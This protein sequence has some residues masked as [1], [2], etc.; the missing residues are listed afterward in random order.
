[1]PQMNWDTARLF[2]GSRF[3]VAGKEGEMH[4]I[5]YPGEPFL[6]QPTEVFAYLGLPQVQDAR[7]PGMVLVHG[8]GGTAFRQ[9]VE[10]WNARGYAAIAMDLSGRGPDGERLPNGGPDQDHPAIFSTDLDWKDLW[11]YHAVAALI[12]ANN[13]LRGLEQ[14]DPG[15]IG[16]TGISWGGY[17]TCIAAGLDPRFGCAIPVYGCGFLQQGSAD[18][19][20]DIFAAMNPE[21]R[22]SWAARCDPSVYLPEARMPMLFVSGTND[23]AYPLNILQQS[24]LLPKGQVSLC[25]RLEMPHGHEEGWAPLEIGFFADQHLRGGR[26]HPRLAFPTRRGR[27]V[28]A[29]IRGG[30]NLC[31]A[32]LLYSRD[33]GRWQDRRWEEASAEIEGASVHA[34]LPP[35]ARVYYLACQDERGGYATSP[36]EELPDWEQ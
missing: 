27:T 6:G 35:G 14:V 10:L 30:M 4:S 21:E 25:V 24:Y 3:R 31:V 18:E 20:M 33:D 5:Y 9:W 13:I 22:Q 12:R 2:S 29:E 23:F 16:L 7:L 15:R 17:L 11:T 32:S 28:Q 36:H 34:S 26:V 19:W 8:G 1:M